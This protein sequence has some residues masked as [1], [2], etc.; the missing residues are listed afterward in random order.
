M[1]AVI[2]I[3]KKK[4]A[5]EITEAEADEALRLLSAPDLGAPPDDGVSTDDMA[6]LDAALADADAALDLVT[7][8]SR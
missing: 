3:A 2:G 7:D 6:E 8:R 1:D 5:G 4:A